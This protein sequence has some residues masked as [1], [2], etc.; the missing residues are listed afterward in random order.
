MQKKKKNSGPKTKLLYPR[1]RYHS[2]FSCTA[3]A[4]HRPSCR[5]L[6]RR[7]VGR[8]V[9]LFIVVWWCREIIPVLQQYAVLLDVEY[10]SNNNNDNKKKTQK[11]KEN[12]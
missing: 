5:Q 8:S 7:L 11:K 12:L 10:T 1:H 9:G 2:S 3:A 6:V 4:A